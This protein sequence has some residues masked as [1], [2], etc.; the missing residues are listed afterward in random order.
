MTTDDMNLWRE[1]WLVCINEL[2]SLN[3][4][5]KSWL[6]MTNANPHWSYV[7]FMCSYFNDLGIDDNYKHPLDKGWL[8][9]QEF[10]IIKEWHEALD[11]YDSSKNDDYGHIAILNDSNWF[12]ILQIGLTMKEKLVATLSERETEILTEE[13]NYLKFV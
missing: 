1:R 11:K 4:Q 9:D 8:T 12:D 2:T 5:K 6:D 3:L 13:I 10:G 7:E